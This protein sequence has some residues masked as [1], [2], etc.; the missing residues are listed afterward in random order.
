MS[1]STLELTPY[2]KF[3]RQSLEDEKK[4]L[5]ELNEQYAKAGRF[6]KMQIK[7][8]L[9]LLNQNIQLLSADLKNYQSGLQWL[10]EPSKERDEIAERLKPV[11]IEAITAQAPKPT[12][13]TVGQARPAPT[14][15]TRPPGSAPSVGRPASVGQPVS[16]QTQ[17]PVQPQ[18]T[19]PSLQAPRVGTPVVGKPVGSPVVGKPVGTPTIQAPRVGIPIGTPGQQPKKEEVT[20]E[21]QESQQEKKAEVESNSSSES[22]SS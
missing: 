14:V 6:K 18:G 4:R 8:Q 19:S 12:T 20:E 11:P 13:L 17:G 1:E 15:G 10:R 2:E 22:Q 3:L 7:R 16:S 21:K 5:A 9:D